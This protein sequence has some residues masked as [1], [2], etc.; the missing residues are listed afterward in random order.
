MNANREKE[1]INNLQRLTC[2][3]DKIDYIER[4][5]RAKNAST[6]SERDSNANVENKNITTL[7]GELSKEDFIWLNRALMY[8]KLTK[9]Y[10]EDIAKEYIRQLTYHEIYQH[11]ETSIYPYCVSM[12]MYPFLVSGLKGLGGVSEAPKHLHSFIGEFI[13]LVFAVAAQFAG[14][15]STPEF[16]T[17]MDYFIRKDYGDNYHL[18]TNENVMITKEKKTLDYVVTSCFQQVTHS[19]NQPAAARNFQSVF[20]NIAYFDKYFFDGIFKDFVFPDGSEPQW[21]SVSW[22]QKR[23]MKWLNSERKNVMLTFPVETVNLLNDG[24][25]YKDEE[26]ADFSAQ[27]YSEGHSFF[28]Y[29]SSTVDSLSSCCRLRNEFNDN[30]FSFTLGAGGVSTGSKDVITIN[31]NRLVQNAYNDQIDISEKIREQAL[32][33][34]KYLLAYNEIVNDLYNADL[35]GAYSA[36]FIQLS[37]QYLTTGVNGFVEG[38]EFLGIDISHNKEYINYCAKVLKPIYEENKKFKTDKVMFNTEFVPA[39]NLGVKNAKW[40]KEDGYYVPRDCYNSYFYIVESD[41]YTI[42]EKIRLHG[43]EFTQYL[44]GGSA[45]HINLEEHLTKDQ[46]RRLMDYEIITGCSYSTYNIPNTICNSCGYISKSKT[47]ICSKCNSNDID[48]ITRIIGYL[49]RISSFSNERQTEAQKR[50]YA[51]YTN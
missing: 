16:L 1:Y 23:Y 2:Q 49:K 36:D 29:T 3:K 37:K 46:Y 40:D 14:A 30:T 50:Y 5:K 42:D 9:M 15:V 31:I 11:D 45:L 6:G 22:L 10:S 25:N 27:M 33:N 24:K 35:L 28:K 20:W 41:K 12:T 43:K 51:S 21:E 18:N 32:K 34:H 8:D 19:L 48:Y 44:D 4:Y 39:E 13:N 17:Y 47:S 7:T 38:A 26:W